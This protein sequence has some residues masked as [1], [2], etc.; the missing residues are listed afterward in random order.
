M[1]TSTPTP[2]GTLQ[3]TR[4][5][6]QTFITYTAHCIGCARN[7]MIEANE[8][9]VT[10]FVCKGLLCNVEVQ[11]PHP[12]NPAEVILALNSMQEQLRLLRENMVALR[13]VVQKLVEM[14]KK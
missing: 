10:C 6:T 7:Y 14:N 13:E 9:P 5:L 8:R 12:Y 4:S 1:N 11:Y 2:L 3:R